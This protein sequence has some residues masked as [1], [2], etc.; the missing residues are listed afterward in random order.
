MCS[1]GKGFEG[2]IDRAA[3]RGCSSTGRAP[4]L[5]AGGRGFDPLQLHPGVLTPGIASVSRNLAAQVNLV[6]STPAAG[7]VRGDRVRRVPT[8]GNTKATSARAVDARF[9]PGFSENCILG[10]DN[11]SDEP[12][13]SSVVARSMKVK[14]LRAHGGCLG[15]RRR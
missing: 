12:E 6:A 11:D 7:G 13:C 9:A 5:Q 4:A 2:K 8:G 1:K 15:A 3:S 14:L 10:N